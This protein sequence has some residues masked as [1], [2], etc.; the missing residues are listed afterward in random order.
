MGQ[1]QNS[2]VRLI[3]ITDKSQSKT[4][5]RIITA[6]QQLHVQYVLIEIQRAFEI[7]DTQHSMK[8]AHDFVPF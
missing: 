7:A 4:A 1:F 8:Q 6:A 5:F 2:M 3:S